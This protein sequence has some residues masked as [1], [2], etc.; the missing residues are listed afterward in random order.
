MVLSSDCPF[1]GQCE[2]MSHYSGCASKPGIVVTCEAHSTIPRASQAPLRRSTAAGD[3]ET[4]VEAVSLGC[5]F[6]AESAPNKSS[7]VG[8]AL[9]RLKHFH[10]PPSEPGTESCNYYSENTAFK[11]FNSFAPNDS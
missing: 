10:S 7:H 3:E 2:A 8:I 9:Q 6:W 4:V 11:L 1:C 5:R